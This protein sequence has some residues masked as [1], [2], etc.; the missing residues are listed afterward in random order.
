MRLLLAP[1][2][3]A[4][5]CSAQEPGDTPSAEVAF[6]AAA[7]LAAAVD[8]ETPEERR[9]AAVR[10][11]R[12]RE[13]SLEEWLEACA[14]FGHFEAVRAGP[15]NERLDLLVEGEREATD[16][17]VYVPPGY[18]PAT[19]APLLLVFHG[20]GGS[21]DGL[22]RLWQSVADELS[23]IVVAPSEA[24]ENVGYGF[25]PRER[26][27]ALAVLRWARRRFNVDENAVFASGISRGGH[28]TWDLALRHPDLFAGV[29]PII[30]GP[31]LLTAHGQNNLRYLENGAHLPIR[32]LQGMRDD[33][34]LVA[35]LERAFAALAEL[36][37]D[38]AVLVDFPE[39]GHDFRL[40]AVD[41]VEFFG[42]RRRDPARARV[43]RLAAELDE[44]RAAWAE[45]TRFDSDVE[46]EPRLVL[47]SG[48][49][50]TMTQDD[51]RAAVHEL[52]DAATARL[53]VERTEPGVFEAEARLVKKARLLV[54][55]EELDEDGRATVVFNG[56]RK[57]KRVRPD[58]QVL[59]LDFVERFDRTYLPTC[60]IP[61]P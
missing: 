51:L 2:V 3:L 39:L 5:P 22:W 9:A 34:L 29:V 10:L 57:R 59:L 40:D 55:A 53:V 13:V 24:G 16:V 41:W 26:A 21:G 36:G 61:L 11:A 30:G 56:R 58:A 54:P 1:L 8:L 23:M 50:E 43:V 14:G 27:S 38:D 25:S 35:S 12:R 52:A 31:R 28:L 15:A 49:V 32:D 20:T 48:Q 37:A 7:E 45:I 46:V 6:D 17:H 60:E 47:R 18:E 42:T 44:A 4:L 33:P 19:P